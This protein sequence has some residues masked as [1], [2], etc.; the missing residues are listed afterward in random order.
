MGSSEKRARADYVR[1]GG[2][3]NLAVISGGLLVVFGILAY[4]SVLKANPSPVDKPAATVQ[5]ADDLDDAET[6]TI[7]VS[8]SAYRGMPACPR[9]HPIVTQNVYLVKP[10]ISFPPIIQK[11]R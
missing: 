7:F 9:L 3:W 2:R 8:I 4:E 1:S 5:E 11:Q 6:A 10:F